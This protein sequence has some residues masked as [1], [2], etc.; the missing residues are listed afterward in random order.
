MKSFTNL[1]ILPEAIPQSIF[2]LSD[3]C[4]KNTSGFQEAA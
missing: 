1:Q 3:V 2:M 4:W